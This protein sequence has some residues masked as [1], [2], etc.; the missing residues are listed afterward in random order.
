MAKKQASSARRRHNTVILLAGA[1]SSCLLGLPT[2]DDILKRAALGEDDVAAR[3][4]HTRE[5]IQAESSRLRTA[6]F[7]DLIVRIKYYLEAAKMLRTDHTFRAEAGHLSYD[8]DN[9]HLERKFKNALT[10]CYRILIDEYGPRTIDP[11]SREF[12]VTADL[13]RALAQIN[14]GQIHVYTTNYDCSFHVL[15]AHRTE[16]AFLTHIDSNNGKFTDSW[17]CSK[18]SA[19]P[20]AC[21]VY[22][23][24]LHGCIAWFNFADHGSNLGGI[25]KEVYGAGS[26]LEI[27]DDDFLDQMCIKLIASQLIGTNPAFA[28][29]F[30]ELCGHLRTAKLL[31]VWGYS[32][33][34]LEVVRA[35]SQA[36][37]ERRSLLR[38]LYLDPLLRE[39]TARENIESVL[40]RAPIQPATALRPRRIAWT[41]NDGLD[42]LVGAVVRAIRGH[43]C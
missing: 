18:P 36:F 39:V 5:S 10:R 1:G 25:V 32:F 12:A 21:K 26:D 24:R 15:A 4:R 23:H 38:V 43:D 2:L 35:I 33:R 19:N 11:H 37:S 28:S 3:I 6:V 14:G 29:A 20:E 42:A 13:L 22:V 9:G 16:L 41:P 17:H 8:V 34:D 30:D 31:L 27:T 7:E 40:L